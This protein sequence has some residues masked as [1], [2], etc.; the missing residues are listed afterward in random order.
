MIYRIALLI[1]ATCLTSS[2]ATA[3]VTMQGTEHRDRY[4]KTRAIERAAVADDTL[5][6]GL[7][8]GVLGHPDARDLRVAEHR[9]GDE[10]VIDL[11]RIVRVGEIVGHHPGFVVGDVLELDRVGD[12]AERPHP[13][14]VGLERT[15]LSPNLRRGVRFEI[16]QVDVRRSPGQVDVDDRLVGT[17]CRDVA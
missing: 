2:C 6:V 9:V 8:G 13:R 7:V 11:D 17:G 5:Y 4:A 16:P 3:L 14:D 10:P 1:A 15:K 12:V